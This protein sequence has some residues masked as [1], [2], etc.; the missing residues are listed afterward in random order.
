MSVEK[1]VV[2]IKIYRF[3]F[4]KRNLITDYLENNLF[5]I[6]GI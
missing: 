6:L 1:L 2:K 5:L 4:D 3:Q